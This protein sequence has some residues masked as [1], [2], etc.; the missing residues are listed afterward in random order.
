MTAYRET[1]NEHAGAGAV[2]LGEGA[3]QPGRRASGAGERESGRAR[4]DEAGRSKV[5]IK[6]R[7]KSRPV[8]SPRAVKFEDD[9]GNTWRGMGKR[10][11]WFKAALASGK[12]P[13]DLLA[14]G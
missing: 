9:Q 5:P 8:T 13:E 3:E 11:A 7:G 2:G 1:L 6:R 10:P 14:K 12:T 4:L